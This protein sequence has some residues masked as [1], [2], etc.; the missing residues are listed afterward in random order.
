MIVTFESSERELRDSK[1]STIESRTLSY[2]LQV[3]G[4]FVD[5]LLRCW[6]VSDNTNAAIITVVH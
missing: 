5:K 2:Y 4:D 6:G 1:Y 3:N